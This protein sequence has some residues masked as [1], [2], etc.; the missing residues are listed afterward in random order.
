VDNA[1]VLFLTEEEW[2]RD[3]WWETPLIM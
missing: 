1:D 3:W 2:N